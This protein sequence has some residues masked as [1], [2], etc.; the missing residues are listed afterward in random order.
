MLPSAFRRTVHEL[1]EGELRYTWMRYLPSRFFIVDFFEELENAIIRALSTE[2]IIE[3][4]G[5][6]LH[7][8]S[9]LSLVQAKFSDDDGLP[10]VQSHVT[11]SKYLS[12][13]YS[14]EKN[15]LELSRLGVK[16]LTPEQFIDDL[17]QFISYS[18]NEFQGMSG[19]WHSSLSR[20]LFR[21]IYEH[22]GLKS[23][24]SRLNIVP[25]KDGRWQSTILEKLCFTDSVTA[26]GIPKR[27]PI[28]EIHPDASADLSRRNLFILLG[29]QTFSK[30]M[31]CQAIISTHASPSFSRQ[32]LSR[33]DLISHALFLYHAGWKN[34]KD[35]FLWLS[36]E[37]GAEKRSY[38]VYVDSEQHNSASAMF[39]SNRGDISFVHGDYFEDISI[40]DGDFKSWLIHTL[41]LADFP[42]LVPHRAPKINLSP[43]FQLLLRTADYLSVL[44]LL[45]DRW[46]QY[47]EF[48][49]P[50]E[51]PGTEAAKVRLR[52][53]IAGIS[54]KCQGGITAR[55][56]ETMLPLNDI[57]TEH[58]THLSF[59]DLPD[60]ESRRWKFL[61]HFG[62]VVDAG[63]APFIQGL[64]LLK[65]GS[66]TL[67]QAS[68]LYKQIFLRSNGQEA[69]LR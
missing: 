16:P 25:L 1:N 4:L 33:Q 26:I 67:E 51:D 58:M 65:E 37:T 61:S 5:G 7:V 45:R 41:H 24:V 23:R 31:V 49:I 29:A 59:I 56:K 21:L 62:V 36:T 53:K 40:L 28:L 39:E 43:E 69:K 22:P 64:Q 12:P 68:E 20:A 32:Q 55:L 50:S 48:I 38:E 47:T 17:D 3:S 57:S 52:E 13:K 2:T 54:V 19:S 46:E 18:P 35:D 14:V 6:D 11:K 66:A 15:L 8:P 9:N 44:K 30:D 10:F 63:V 60:P 34:F 42:R 27:I